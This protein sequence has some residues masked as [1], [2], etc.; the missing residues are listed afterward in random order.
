MTSL[1]PD[2]WRALTPDPD[3]A[4]KIASVL[5]SLEKDFQTAAARL[6]RFAGSALVFRPVTD[7][8]TIE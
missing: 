7:E 6:D 1:L 5:S 3:E 8:D 2:R 4:E